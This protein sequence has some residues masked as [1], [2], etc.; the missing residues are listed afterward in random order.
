MQ[1]YTL[2]ELLSYRSKGVAPG[3]V[4]LNAFN[5][6]IDE[7]RAKLEPYE[8]EGVTADGIP[9][10]TF[11]RRSLRLEAKPHFKKK[12]EPDAEGWVTMTARKSVGAADAE[13]FQPVVPVV[14][15]KPNTKNIGTR[16]AANTTEAVAEKTVKK[17]NAFS[18][19]VSDSEDD[20]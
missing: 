3:S 7:V 18:A 12:T 16:A 20:E 8:L 4:D 17:F 1:K 13:E 15:V 2:E 6:M 11:R 5:A 19:L 10:Y 14:R 9:K